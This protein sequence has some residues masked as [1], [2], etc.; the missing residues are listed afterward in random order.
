MNRHERATAQRAALGRRIRS[1][2]LALGLTSRDV[3]AH[4]QTGRTQ[5][6]SIESNTADVTTGVLID[7][8]EAVGLAVV[9]AADHHLPLLDLTSAEVDA[10][11]E[12]LA[13]EVDAHTARRVPD[14]A[15][16]LAKLNAERPAP[17]RPRPGRIVV[18]TGQIWQS[19]DPRP[20]RQHLRRVVDIGDSFAF[21][22]LVRC[23]E[24]GRITDDA[25]RRRVRL[26]GGQIPGHDYIGEASA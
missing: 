9:L 16:A 2:R 13:R 6:T 17:R 3:A 4:V 12:V 26:H 22:T 24:T 20:G 15:S 21:A 11:R 1:Y 18:A 19:R 10:V 25:R 14:V 5:M 7:V 23:D 8:A